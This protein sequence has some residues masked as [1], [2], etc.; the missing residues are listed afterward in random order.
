MLALPLIF[1]VML[2]SGWTQVGKYKYKFSA[3][4]LARIHYIPLKTALLRDFLVISPIF[5]DFG[6]FMGW[7]HGGA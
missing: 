2:S 5:E 3:C 7:S 4:Y 6:R 1:Q